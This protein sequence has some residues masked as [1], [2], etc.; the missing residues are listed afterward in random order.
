MA[1]DYGKLK[2]LWSEFKR[3]HETRLGVSTP[4][5]TNFFEAEPPFRGGTQC[6]YT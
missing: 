4:L 3:L 1:E 6:G 5:A 2:P